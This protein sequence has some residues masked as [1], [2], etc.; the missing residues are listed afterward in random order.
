MDGL[1]VGRFY[2]EVE[3]YLHQ[4]EVV[5]DKVQVRNLIHAGK[6]GFQL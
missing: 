3:E 6:H 5:L 4:P 2:V 1:H